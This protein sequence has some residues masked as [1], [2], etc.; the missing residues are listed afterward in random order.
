MKGRQSKGQRIDG[1]LGASVRLLGRR[2]N[3]LSQCWGG[4]DKEEAKYVDVQPTPRE[5]GVNVR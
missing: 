1:D 3:K 4:E 2:A 5:W